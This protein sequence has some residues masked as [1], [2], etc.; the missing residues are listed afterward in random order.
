MVFNY[1][2]CISWSINVTWYINWGVLWAIWGK[3][4]NT[5]NGVTIWSYGNPLKESILRKT[6][7]RKR[8][9]ESLS[10]AERKRNKCSLKKEQFP[11]PTFLF[12]TNI[13][14]DNSFKKIET[15]N[16]GV[17]KFNFFQRKKIKVFIN[18]WSL[19]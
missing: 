17:F 10:C 6:Q 12:S 19:N 11:S 14:S 9:N 15:K 3:T 16:M 7:W 8:E 5:M 1:V 13:N 2:F 4:G 18:I